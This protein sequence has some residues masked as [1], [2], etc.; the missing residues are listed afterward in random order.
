[1]TFHPLGELLSE[2]EDVTRELAGLYRELAQVQMAEH[3]GKLEHLQWSE[4]DTVTARQRY[5]EFQVV[6]LST[7]RIKLQGEIA[8]LRE[9]KDFLMSAIGTSRGRRES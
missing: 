9:R 3:R 7:D 6:D 5:A 8:A 2:L 1:M 4:E